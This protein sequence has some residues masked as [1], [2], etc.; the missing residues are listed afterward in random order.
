M[1]NFASIAALAI[2]A[3]ASQGFAASPNGFSVVQ[4]DTQLHTTFATVHPLN[5]IDWKVGD[6]ADYDVSGGAFGKIGKMHKEV[7]KD[8]GT[9]IWVSQNIDLGFQKDSSEMLINK[10]DGKVLKVIRNGKEEKLPDDKIEIISQDVEDI[11]VP[12]GKFQTIHIVAKTKQVSR[13]E[14]WVNPRDT[15]M[16]GT[17][18]QFMDTGML[19]ITMEL[20]SF[21]KMP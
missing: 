2:M 18:K 8:E 9:A 15:V 3:F 13:I 12:A 11:E 7:T 16:E 1:K 21:T 4:I 10:A 19:Q 5:V 6:L 14:V 20:V 17:V